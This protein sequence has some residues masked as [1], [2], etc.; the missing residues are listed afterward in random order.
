MGKHIEFEFI[1]DL[2][3]QSKAI[4]SVIALFKGLPKKGDSIYGATYRAKKLNEKEPIRNIG[5]IEGNRLLDNLN[6]VQLENNLFTSKCIEGNNFTIEME[7][8]TG[9]TYVY[10]RTILE[11][12]YEYDFTKFIIVVPS[13]AIRTGLEKSI[14]MLKDHFKS[15]YGVDIKNHSFVYNSND[16]DNIS[17]NLVET[18]EISIC[19]MNIQAFNKDKNKIRQ[20]D[21]YGQV[22]WRDIQTIRPIVII[23][24]PQKIEGNNKKKSKSLEAIEE[25]KPLFTLRYSA[26]HKK[27]YNQIYK[28]DSYDAFHQDLVKRIE[29]KTIN[30]TIP[31]DK[32]Y[33]KYLNFTKD[34]KAK[35]EI[36]HQEQGGRITFKTFSVLGNDSLY[37]LS[38]GLTQY[39]DVRVHENPHKLKPLKIATSENIIEL[40]EEESNIT[41]HESEIIRYQIRLT[42]K[43]HLDK[44]FYILDKGEKIKVLSLFFIDEVYKVRDNEREDTRGEYLRIFDEEYKNIIEELHYKAKFNEYKDSFKNYNDELAVREGYFAVDK[45]K[46]VVEVEGWNFALEENKLKAKS[47]E[48]VDRGIELILEKKDELISFE[49]P[50]AFIFSHSALREG[51]DNP[52]VFNICTLKQGSSDIAKKQEIGRGLRLPVDTNGKRCTNSDINQLTVIANDNYEHFATA[53]QKDYNDNMEFDKNEITPDIIIKTFQE[54]GVPK[55][56]ITSALVN[57][58]KDELVKKKIINSNNILTKEAKEIYNVEFKDE[59]LAEHATLI[60]QN[61]A[62]YMIERGSR[63]IPV[64]NGDNDPIEANAP[65]SYVSE[66]VFKK[67]INK[68]TKNLKKRAIYRAKIDKDK[69]IEESGRE[70]NDYT[71][72]MHGSMEY[73]IETGKASY[74]NSRRFDMGEGVKRTIEDGSDLLIERKSDLEIINY[75]MYHTMLP[76]FAII[77][78]LGQIKNRLI[79]NKQDVLEDITKRIADKLNKSKEV[80]DYE[81]IQGYELDTLKILEADVINESMLED[82]KKYI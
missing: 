57:V 70:L 22:I 79:L 44:Q 9:K 19:I 61:L 36:F 54:A 11:L 53:L 50:L 71:K 26:T 5:I 2:H 76:R 47:Q 21:E 78:I 33:I 49:E 12:N 42:I 80:Y 1:K 77:K 18:R 38:G 39:K 29:V 23:D 59:I 67:I 60:K 69:F 15:L 72:Y 34:L 8:G 40:N 75:I 7:T 55:E 37:D 17:T 52:N 66:E 13:V 24:E 32:A 74:D 81:V 25:L 51:W 41:F 58:L 3:H 20:E 45:N 27:L 28:L 48:D 6:K 64:I 65:H 10:L 30:S 14:D 31:K 43:A 73:N 56:K 63:K 4:N 46:A 68:L 16:M 35:I 82:E 62:K